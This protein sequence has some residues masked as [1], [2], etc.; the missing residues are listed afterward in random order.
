M[1]HSRSQLHMAHS[2]SHYTWHTAGLTT[3]GTQQVSNIQSYTESIQHHPL[4]TVCSGHSCTTPTGWLTLGQEG[5]GILGRC[6]SSATQCYPSPP[7]RGRTA[8]QPLVPQT[9]S[10]T[11]SGPM[12]A[13][14]RISEQGRTFMY[15][16]GSN[17][18]LDRK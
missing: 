6:P 11:A 17:I 2:R 10:Q 12:C 3:Q 15:W 5:G 14:R 1:A 9:L 4:G 13:Y 18:I 16:T 7:W 8:D